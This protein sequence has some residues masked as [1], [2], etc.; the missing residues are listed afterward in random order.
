MK[1][2]RKRTRSF[3][4]FSEY[5]TEFSFAEELPY[6]DFVDNLVVLAD[7]TLVCGLKVRGLSVE[8]WDADAINQLT[9]GLRSFLNAVPDGWEL[10]FF[11]DNNSEW[12]DLLD[13]YEKFKSGKSDLDWLRDSRLLLLREQAKNDEILKSDLFLFIYKRFSGEP[14]TKLSFFSSPKLFQETKKRLHEKAALELKQTTDVVTASLNQLGMSVAPISDEEMRSLA[15]R[16]LNP[17]LSSSHPSPKASLQHRLQEFSKIELAKEPA[18]SLPS[19]REQLVYSDVVAGYESF[20]LDGLYHGVVTLKTMPEFTHS[21][22]VSS[23]MSLPFPHVLQIHVR[24]PEQSKELSSLQAKRRMA[25]SMSI[26]QGGRATD[27][28]SEARLNSTEELLRE[29]INTGQKIFYF[30]LSVLLRADTKEAL[31]R[32]TRSVLSK[33][34]ELNGAEVRLSVLTRLDRTQV[35]FPAGS[36]VFQTLKFA[37]VSRC[38]VSSQDT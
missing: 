6:W 28:E 5:Q 32:L 20:Y 7:G 26:S 9:L 33:A 22:L 34:R 36:I 2:E 19:P 1:M 27:L 30:Q 16:F 31:E 3:Q 12:K 11:V 23:F 37:A 15:F 8:A 17:K 10:S 18:L 14:K 38:P 29:L 4:L 13:D 21:S 24:V 25:H 35:K